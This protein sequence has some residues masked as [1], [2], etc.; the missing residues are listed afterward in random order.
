MCGGNA[1]NGKDTVKSG[2]MTGIHLRT[3]RAQIGDTTPM[4][5]EGKPLSSGSL[6]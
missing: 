1:C 3:T 4:V 5:L 2:Y 6:K